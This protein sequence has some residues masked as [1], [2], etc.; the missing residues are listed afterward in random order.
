[1]T[2]APR[3]LPPGTGFTW[4][5]P[6]TTPAVS[7]TVTTNG[8]G[9]AQFQWEPIPPEADSAATVSEALKAD[10]T[11]GRPGPNND[12]ACDLK[13]EDGHVRTVTGELDLSNP[14]SPRHIVAEPDRAGHRDLQGLEL[15]QL[16]SRHPAAEGQYSDRRPR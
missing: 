15:V 7:K 14:Q 12:F 5:L 4:I 11:P 13:D 2:V 9:F 6:N 3:A 8:N 10:Y 16:R 1:M